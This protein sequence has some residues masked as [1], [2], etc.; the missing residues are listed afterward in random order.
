MPKAN[1]RPF[2]SGGSVKNRDTVV[3]FRGR[4]D[5]LLVDVRDVRGSP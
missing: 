4:R 5:A 2:K 1:L 3:K